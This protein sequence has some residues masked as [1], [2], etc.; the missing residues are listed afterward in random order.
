MQ[1]VAL[2][3]RRQNRL[4][5]AENM[6]RDTLVALNGNTSLKRPSGGHPWVI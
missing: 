6:Y 1:N 4:E 5:E 3:L 2:A